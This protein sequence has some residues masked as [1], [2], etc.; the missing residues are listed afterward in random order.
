M[1]DPDPSAAAVLALRTS[2]FYD[3][4]ERQRKAYEA[5]A[6]QAYQAAGRPYRAQ[7]GDLPGALLWLQEAA[8]LEGWAW[9]DWLRCWHQFLG[10]LRREGV[11]PKEAA[12]E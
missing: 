12:R 1:P 3:T 11:V 6:V 2:I 10:E 9:A 4:M 5:L 7:L 8:T